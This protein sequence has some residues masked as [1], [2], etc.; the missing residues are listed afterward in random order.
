MQ[1]NMKHLLAK[2]AMDQECIQMN[3]IGAQFFNF[4][5]NGYLFIILRIYIVTGVGTI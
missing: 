3:K 5:I 1:D 4:E 2:V